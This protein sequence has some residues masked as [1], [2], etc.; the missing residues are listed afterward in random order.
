MPGIV[1]EIAVPSAAG[2]W[3][4][5]HREGLAVRHL[6]FRTKLVEHRFERDF[7]RRGDVNFLA[8][9]QRIH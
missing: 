2:P 1:T 7:D 6:S 3:L 8:N 9:L 5:C 4:D